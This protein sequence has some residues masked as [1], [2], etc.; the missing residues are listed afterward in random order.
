MKFNS[1]VK[2][3]DVNIIIGKANF[4]GIGIDFKQ[5]KI[6]AFEDKNFNYIHSTDEISKGLIFFDRT[7]FKEALDKNFERVKDLFVYSAKC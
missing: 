7:K 4:K 3:F 1:L 2:D 6:S 5:E